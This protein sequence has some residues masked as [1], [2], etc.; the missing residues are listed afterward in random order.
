MNKVDY[1]LHVHEDIELMYKYYKI[2]FH[3]AVPVDLYILQEDRLVWAGTKKKAE[4]FLKKNE[5]KYCES[6][7]EMWKS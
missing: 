3:H 1:N 4:S 7:Y 2:P 5:G 6:M